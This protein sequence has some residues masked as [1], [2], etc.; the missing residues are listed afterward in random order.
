MNEV[1]RYAL[2]IMAATVPR[3]YLIT[4][5]SVIDSTPECV[6]PQTCSL[7]SKFRHGLGGRRWRLKQLCIY[8]CIPEWL[9][10]SAV[11]RRRFSVDLGLRV[12]LTPLK[13]TSSCVLAMWRLV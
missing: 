12:C 6:Q 2:L 1:Y 8:G 4:I 5:C 11:W 13:N 3:H 7:Y 10:P 9:I